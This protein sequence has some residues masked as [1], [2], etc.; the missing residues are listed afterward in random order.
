[1]QA[2]SEYKSNQSLDTTFVANPCD[3]N[4][5][6][7]PILLSFSRHPN[8]SSTQ[9]TT[10]MIMAKKK[11]DIKKIMHTTKYVRASQPFFTPNGLRSRAV[12]T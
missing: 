1:M 10:L 9:N 3:S 6:T 5:W 8:K 12:L 7:R 11:K 2:P 4:N